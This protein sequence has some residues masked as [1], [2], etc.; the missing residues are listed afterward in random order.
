MIVPTPL[1]I[2]DANL[3]TLENLQG[4]TIVYWY[5][6]WNGPHRTVGAYVDILCRKLHDTLTVA[7]VEADKNPSAW[8]KYS[9]HGV[10]CVQVLDNGE[11]VATMYGA[12]TQQQLEKFAQDTHDRA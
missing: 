10:P 8:N 6:E 11:L 12:M 2:T 7:R 9:V 3:D 1:E 4:R 5:A